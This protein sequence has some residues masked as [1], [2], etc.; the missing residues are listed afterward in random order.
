M[1]T[2]SFKFIHIIHNYFH[3]VSGLFKV[4]PSVE[5]FDDFGNTQQTNFVTVHE[6]RLGTDILPS[7][8]SGK[9]LTKHKL[10]G[11]LAGEMNTYKALTNRGY[12]PELCRDI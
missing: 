6:S 3:E 9:V 12:F 11:S 7:D 2:N 10:P 5:F 1:N 8:E 4:H